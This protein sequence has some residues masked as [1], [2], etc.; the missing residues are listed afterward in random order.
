MDLLRSISANSLN[1][2]IRHIPSVQV[3]N[4][5]H[6]LKDWCLSNITQ[7]RKCAATDQEADSRLRGVF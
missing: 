2:T 3:R 5:K 7:E 1:N 6:F 4:Y